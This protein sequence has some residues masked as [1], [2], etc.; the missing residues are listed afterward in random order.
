MQANN[1]RPNVFAIPRQALLVLTPA[2][3]GLSRPCR[4]FMFFAFPSQFWPRPTAARPGQARPG[5]PCGRGFPGFFYPLASMAKAQLVAGLTPAFRLGFDPGLPW[6]GR[7]PDAR[8]WLFWVFYHNR[9]TSFNLTTLCVLT[10]FLR[11]CQ[12]LTTLMEEWLA[13]FNPLNNGPNALRMEERVFPSKTS[14]SS[15]KNMAKT[16]GTI[17]LKKRWVLII[18][19]LAE[20]KI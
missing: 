13:I 2:S 8:V 10:S 1:C 11:H 16:T 4:P 3:R 19:L 17:F 9:E 12:T 6:S 18:P 5:W 20:K 15:K 14:M 7:V